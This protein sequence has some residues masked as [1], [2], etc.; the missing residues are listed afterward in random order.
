MAYGDGP[1]PN[2]ANP[3]ALASPAVHQRARELGAR[4][5]EQTP[6]HG[7]S[8][9]EQLAVVHYKDGSGPLNR[10]L[11]MAHAGQS[12]PGASMED[13]FADSDFKTIHAK[14]QSGFAKITKPTEEEFSTFSGVST[15]MGRKIKATKQG[16][17]F[18]SPAWVSSSLN[19][20]VAHNFAA[21]DEG[22]ESH[23]VQFKI[24]KG[25]TKGTYIGHAFGSFRH[26]FEYT[27]HAG[28]KWKR[29]R[30]VV[31]DTGYGDHKTY[32]HVM[33]PAD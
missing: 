11:V 27:I 12:K 3:N 32:L 18:H 7:M 5:Q 9:S 19:P 16:E 30:T 2:Y 23:V 4:L 6:I 10:R 33:E 28:T 1:Q 21:G 31:H 8:A 20:Q 17:T 24:P 29:T 25:Y 22:T 14:I 13:G 15:D 26:E